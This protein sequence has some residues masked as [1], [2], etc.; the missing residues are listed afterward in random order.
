[1]EAEIKKILPPLF[2]VIFD[3]WDQEGGCKFV[4]V[5]ASFLHKGSLKKGTIHT[6]HSFANEF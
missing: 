1:M 6:F 5:F 4:A 3:G 2:A